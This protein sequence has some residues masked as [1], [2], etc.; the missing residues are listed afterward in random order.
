VFRYLADK[1]QSGLRILCERAPDATDNYIA[2]NYAVLQRA[3]RF[4]LPDGGLLFRSEENKTFRFADLNHPFESYTLEYNEGD[5]G[6]VLVIDTVWNANFFSVTVGLFGKNETKTG[7]LLS[8]WMLLEKAAP[9]AV[10]SVK[11]SSA[12][13]TWNV[14]SWNV[15]V[16]ESMPSDDGMPRLVPDNE[17]SDI[18]KF[19]HVLGD[20]L[21]AMNSVGT[22]VESTEVSAKLNAK[23]SKQNKE[24]LSTYRILDLSML[25]RERVVRDLSKGTHASPALHDRRGHMRKLKTGKTVWVKPCRVGKEENGIVTKSYSIS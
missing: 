6:V 12:E 5:V 24:P 2:T 15:A 25:D 20:F 3:K 10:V 4:A 8:E 19:L 11:P 18:T 13:D 16:Y 23:R 21:V 9:G 14:E 7:A 17:E 22:R 1:L